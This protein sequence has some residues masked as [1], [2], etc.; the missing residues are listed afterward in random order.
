MKMA[1]RRAERLQDVPLSVTA[2]SAEQ[3]T[4][5]GITNTRDLTLAVPGLKMDFGGVYMQP[6]IRGISS[7]IQTPQSETNVAT[8]VDGVYQPNSL[9]GVYQLPDVRQIE[10]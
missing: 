10:V 9:S 6:A 3:L 7:T 1:Q 8:Y 5:S 2:V 4:A